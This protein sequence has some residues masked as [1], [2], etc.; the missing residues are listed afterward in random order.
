MIENREIV[1][2]FTIHKYEYLNIKTVSKVVLRDQVYEVPNDNYMAT[3][4]LR[5]FKNLIS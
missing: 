4:I 2:C 5:Y 3:A 1:S